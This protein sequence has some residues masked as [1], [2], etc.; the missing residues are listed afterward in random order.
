MTRTPHNGYRAVL[1]ARTCTVL[2]SA[3]VL[4]GWLRIS[5]LAGYASL[6]V[7][8]VQFDL[9]SFSWVSTVELGDFKEEV[10]FSTGWCRSYRLHC[11]IHY[12]GKL[13]FYLFNLFLLQSSTVFIYLTFNY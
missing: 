9:D 12:P 3:H 13:K 10:L 2:F 4:T 1:I 6:V 5:E 7:A 11:N 8:S